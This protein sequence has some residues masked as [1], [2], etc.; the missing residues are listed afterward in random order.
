MLDTNVL[1]SGTL[2]AEGN[3]PAQV[4]RAWLDEQRFRLA[5]S[6]ALLEEYRRVLFRPVLRDLSPWT[7]QEIQELLSRIETLAEIRVPGRLQVQVCRDPEDD[8]VIAVAVEARADYLVSGDKD[9]LSLK[10]YEGVRI[11]SPAEFLG[12]LERTG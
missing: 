11:V 6:P 7:D 9:L 12:Q 5:I 2:K 8:K 10:R 3:P 4:L 1:V